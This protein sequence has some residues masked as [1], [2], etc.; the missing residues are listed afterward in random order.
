MKGDEDTKL[1]GLV[2]LHVDM[3]P[4]IVSLTWHSMGTP[5][6]VC[7]ADKRETLQVQ[8]KFSS[9]WTKNVPAFE[10]AEVTCAS[11]SF[12]MPTDGR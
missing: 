6:H 3:I 10:G 12:D 4:I 11:R 2:G 8:R 5:D 9:P 1:I 7:D